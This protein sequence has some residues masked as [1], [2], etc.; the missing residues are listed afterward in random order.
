MSI[1]FS[2]K[3]EKLQQHCDFPSTW[4]DVDFENAVDR[5]DRD[6]PCTGRGYKL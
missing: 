2:D 4:K 6:D 3:Y 5:Y 1:K